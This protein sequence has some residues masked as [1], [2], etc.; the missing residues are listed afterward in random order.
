MPGRFAYSPDY[1]IGVAYSLVADYPNSLPIAVDGNR[2]VFMGKGKVF[3]V[4]N[5]I[6]VDYFDWEPYGSQYWD[7]Q[8]I[9]QEKWGLRWVI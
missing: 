1:I 4:E 5:G 3:L 2:C 7:T 9:A 6:V 8:K